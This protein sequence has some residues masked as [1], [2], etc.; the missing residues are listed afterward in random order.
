MHSRNGRAVFD[1]VTKL[2][3]VELVPRP[4]WGRSLA[5]IARKG[6]GRQW[7]AVRA[8]EMS[9]TNGN[10]E[11]CGGRGVLVHEHWEYDDL[12]GVQYLA[13][14]AVTCDRCSLV[15]HFGRAAALGGEGEALAHLMAVNRISQRDAEQLVEQAFDNWEKRSQ[16]AWVQDLAWLRLRVS[17]Y[18]LTIDDVMR[19][20]QL[21]GFAS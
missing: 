20:E 19:A 1:Q 5:G 6:W 3:N 9:K 13:G 8:K 2:L 10:C 11:Y 21:L 16:K 15:H 14:F 4:S 18:G 12:K 17:D 7:D